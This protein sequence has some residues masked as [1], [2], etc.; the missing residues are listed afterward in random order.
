MNTQPQTE[1]T[2]TEPIVPLGPNE[3]ACMTCGVA[4][5]GPHRRKDVEG[6]GTTWKLLIPG[7]PKAGNT[8]VAA[9][10]MTRCADCRALRQLALTLLDEHPRVQQG[11]GSR[12]IA[13]DRVENA[14][15]ALD[16]L[17]QAAPTLRTDHDLRLLIDPDRGLATG[18]VAWRSE[19][20]NSSWQKPA[21]V[22]RRAAS[23]RWAHV[24][25]EQRQALRDGFAAMLR[26]RTERPRTYAP[27]TDGPRGCLLCGV[28]TVVALPSRS[29]EVWTVASVPARA[30][31]GRGGGGSTLHGYL[32]PACSSAVEEAGGVGPSA[33]EL[34]LRRHLGVR[35]RGYGGP[36]EVQLVGLVGW[37]AL[38]GPVAVNAMRWQ[39]V[40]AE[41]ARSLL[42]G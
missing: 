40:D 5:P 6:F 2:Q 13:L 3:M 30:L 41:E 34:S 23:A 17:G 32:C 38:P 12:S 28:G 15:A 21:D 16:V 29:T 10:M 18:G 35:Q 25:Q 22:P 27:P 9:V 19:Y 4:V 14:L 31:G 7:S 11:V 33:M 39:H 42:E 24:G 8:P 26:A 1:D 20:A 37:G 36:G